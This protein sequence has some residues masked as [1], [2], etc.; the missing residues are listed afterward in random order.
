MSERSSF[1]AVEA[2]TAPRLYFG[3]RW[4]DLAT[5]HQSDGA[6]LR[7]NERRLLVYLAERPDQFASIDELHREVWG[8]SDKV[9]TRAAYSAVNRLRALIEPDPAEPRYLLSGRGGYW[10]TGARRSDAAPRR[11][12]LPNP[13]TPFVGRAA[14]LEELRRDPSRLRTL[15]GPG[16]VGKSR[17]ALELAR[18]ASPP[19]GV[20]WI[21]LRNVTSVDAW[22]A[23][24]T[25]AL[26]N[27]DLARLGPAWVVLD[28][29]EGVSDL[30]PAVARW[31]EGAPELTLLVTSRVPLGVYGEKRVVV[32][33]LEPDDAR[34]LLTTRAAAPLDEGTI[35]ELLAATERHPLALEI[36]AAHVGRRSRGELLHQALPGSR[37]T[38]ASV[39]ERSWGLLGDPD[40]AALAAL[41]AIDGGFDAR[42]AEVATG[43]RSLEA[44]LDASWLTVEL[45]GSEA[46]M[47]VLAV[48]RAF[49]PDRDPTALDR[50]LAWVEAETSAAGPAGWL[51]GRGPR[52]G[53]GAD[54]HLQLARRASTRAAD[55]RARVV[56]GLA[57]SSDDARL[58]GP[59]DAAIA[60][61]PDPVLGFHLR[62]WLVTS[63]YAAPEALEPV[64]DDPTLQAVAA[65]ERAEAGTRY[66]DWSGAVPSLERAESLLPEVDPS[67]R[68]GLQVRLLA[69]W[70]GVRRD[71]ERVEVSL[72]A[73]VAD[74]GPDTPAEVLAQVRELQLLA[75]RVHYRWDE[76]T[77]IGGELLALTER[78]RARPPLVANAHGAL[79]V[80]AYQ[81]LRIDDARRHAQLA[82]GALRASRF[83]EQYRGQLRQAAWQLHQL[84]A[85]EALGWLAEAESTESDTPD[86]EVFAPMHRSA[87]AAAADGPA[88]GLPAAGLAVTRARRSGV[89]LAHA[90]AWAMELLTGLGDDDGALAVSDPAAS[91]THWS[92]VDLT[93]AELLLRRRDEAGAL[94]L[95]NGVLARSEPPMHTARAHAIA[96]VCAARA[97]DGPAA[98]LHLARADV[99]GYGE[100]WIAHHRREVET[101][102]AGRPYDGWVPRSRP[103][104]RRALGLDPR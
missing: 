72:R 41:A 61:G 15:L 39:V 55:P 76:A 9:R 70:T 22:D 44:L 77:R 64:P 101:G 74:T 36:V 86:G 93:R 34:A 67:L 40:R 28:D 26:G 42:A 8:F 97:G 90:V 29:A 45:A 23:V 99:R 95:A 53:L 82:V 65:L 56:L 89:Y 38:L 25:A 7:P 4:V 71:P 19:G 100:W 11:G 18:A 13:L 79:L 24:A 49:V 50:L 3:S 16:G 98:A 58:R 69:G 104:T 2:E 59:V 47:R 80:A 32:P 102:S 5:G 54:A 31:L 73:L 20:W 35:A 17:L 21:D 43:G 33:P 92:L 63:A 103:G 14:L 91:V 62:R 6:P 75:A 46:W 87:L 88:A 84:D 96:A 60:A 27:P 12:V 83:A 85:P 1:A 37:A 52:F 66:G 51:S 30:G 78:F 81:Q 10:L 48:L 57:L 94:A 68:T